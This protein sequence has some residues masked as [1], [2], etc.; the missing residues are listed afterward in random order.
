VSIFIV[1]MGLTPPFDPSGANAISTGKDGAAGATRN[2]PFGVVGG[3]A[4]GEHSA[5]GYAIQFL[6]H[7]TWI[8][9]RRRDRGSDD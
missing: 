7:L 2:E 4:L 9:A 1:T 8:R 5:H 6:G 3:G